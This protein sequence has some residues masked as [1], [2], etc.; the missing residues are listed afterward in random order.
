VY[1][2]TE[3]KKRVALSNPYGNWIKE[4]LRSLKPGNF[5]STSVMDNDADFKDQVVSN[6]GKKQRSLH[7]RVMEEWCWEA[8]GSANDIHDKMAKGI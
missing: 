4:K 6:K 1:E 5:L 7:Q 3:V 8:I 2:N